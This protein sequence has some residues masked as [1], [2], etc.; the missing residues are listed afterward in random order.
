M[1]RVK[2]C[3]ITAGDD[4]EAA[5]A[6]GADAL[7][8]TVS[9]PVD[10]PREIAP[11]Q[12]RTLIDAVPPFVSTVLVTMPDDLQE[13]AALIDETAPDAVQVHGDLS[14]DDLADLRDA[15]DARVIRAI[16]TTEVDAAG[17]AAAVADALLVDA[18]T[19]SGRG[20][21]GQTA[22]WE[23]TRTLCREIDVP[24]ILAGGLTPD[25]VAAAVRTVE[26]Y[27]VDVASGVERTGGRKDHDAVAAFVA[28]AVGALEAV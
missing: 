11:E 6:A 22:D 23:R 2:I 10:T 15:V 16:A 19:E 21:T 27:A 13:T 7:G 9:V 12:A 26:P 25:T 1:T 24:M 18:A 14:V 5:V 8:F 28:N 17:R 20:G 3:G 4:L